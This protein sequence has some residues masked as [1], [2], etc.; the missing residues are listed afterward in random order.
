MLVIENQEKKFKIGYQNIQGLHN[1]EGCKLKECDANL[2]NDIEI[3]GETWGCKCEKIFSEYEVL[4]RSE[5]QKHQGVTK[6]RK[7]GGLLVLGKKY[8][9]N[10]VKTKKISIKF[11]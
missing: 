1:K 2:F 5:P 4:A 3:L 9:L 8:L 6:G 11:C 10:F 7:S